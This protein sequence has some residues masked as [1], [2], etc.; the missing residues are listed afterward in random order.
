MSQV[1]APVFAE[2]A[3]RALGEGARPSPQRVRVRRTRSAR[4]TRV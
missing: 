1:A 4:P 3:A 2:A